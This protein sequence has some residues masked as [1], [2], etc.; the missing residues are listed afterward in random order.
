[1]ELRGVVY[2]LTGAGALVRGEDGGRYFLP[3]SEALG[4]WPRVGDTYLFDVMPTDRTP[5]AVGA[6]FLQSG[7]TV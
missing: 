2:K 5:L 4:R 1:M 3:R 6:R 7:P